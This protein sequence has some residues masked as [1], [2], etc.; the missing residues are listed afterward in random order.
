M[1]HSLAILLNLIVATPKIPRAM[2]AGS[3]HN[4]APSNRAIFFAPT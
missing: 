2:D 4:P 1:G 3:L